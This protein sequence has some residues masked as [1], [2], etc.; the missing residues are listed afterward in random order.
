MAKLTRTTRP[1]LR[2]LR[3]PL[4]WVPHVDDPVKGAKKGK[5]IEETVKIENEVTYKAFMDAAKQDRKNQAHQEE[6]YGAEYF[7]VV[8]QDGKQ[9]SHFLKAA[10]YPDYLDTFIDG[11]ILAEILKVKLPAS[12]VEPRKLRRTH[13]ASLTSLS[14]TRK[15][16]K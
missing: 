3:E 8:F 6:G 7:V 4:G 12:T 2:R 16:L 1:A 11:T 10:G 13:D 9:A 15:G 5:T 14:L